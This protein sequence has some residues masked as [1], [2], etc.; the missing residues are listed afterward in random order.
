MWRYFTRNKTRRYVD[1][2][3]DLLYNYNHSF[4]RSIQRTPAEVNSSNVLEVWKTLYGKTGKTGIRKSIPS[5]KPKFRVGDL[6]RI[7]KAKKTFD[8]GYLPNWT[9][10]LF[11]VSKRIPDR[12]PYVY[13]IQDYNKEEL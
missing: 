3:P 8:K 13:K 2:L 10:E 1:I 6:V 7:S 4:H 12:F 5:T 11:T 9:T